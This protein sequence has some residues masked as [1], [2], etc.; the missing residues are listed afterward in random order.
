MLRETVGVAVAVRLIVARSQQQRCTC[1]H[2]T[3]LRK[4]ASVWKENE[5]SAVFFEFKSEELKI[6]EGALTRS[7]VYL[8][9]SYLAI[10]KPWGVI[11]SFANLN[12]VCRDSGENNYM[13]L[14]LEKKRARRRDEENC[15]HVA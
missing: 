6:N 7:R 3:Q 4:P 13:G 8:S 14:A 9:R 5:E 15:P 12:T 1:F 10:L 2:T 11:S